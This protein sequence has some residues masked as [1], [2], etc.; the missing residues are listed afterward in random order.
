MDGPLQDAEVVAGGHH[1]AE[2]RLVATAAAQLVGD[3]L[4]ALVPRVGRVRDHAILV[5][6]RQLQ[7]WQII[8]SR[9]HGAL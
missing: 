9:L 8:L 2:L 7:I 3:G 4:V 1:G 5:H 6:W